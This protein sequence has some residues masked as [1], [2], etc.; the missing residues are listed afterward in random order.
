MKIT[1][2]GTINKDLILPF[3]GAPIESFGG[4]FYDVAVL[5]SLLAETDCIQPVAFVGEDVYE[6]VCTVLEKLP[7]VST[8]GL[9]VLPQKN[10]KVILEYHSPHHRHEKSLFQ[11]PPLEWSHIEPFLDAEMIIVNLICG[12]DL[13]REAFVQLSRQARNHLYLDVHYLVMGIDNLGRRFPQK[14]ERVEDWLTGARF[15]QM[16]ED[17]FRLLAE[18]FRNEVEFYQHYFEEDQILLITRAARG[19]EVVYRREGLVGHKHFPAYAVSQVMDATGCGDAFGAGFVVHYLQTGD[20][21]KAA[22][23]GNLVAAANTQLRGTNEMHRLQE[24]IETIRMANL[25][26]HP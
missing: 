6:T 20:F 12:W 8:D 26:K 24:T 11:F 18:G 19:A 17:E 25:T 5:S 4:I 2:I 22:D 1:V 3:G 9:M 14:P 16:N 23:F 15:V 13:R 21:L 10:H 7:N